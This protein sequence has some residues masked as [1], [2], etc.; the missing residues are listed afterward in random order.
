MQTLN[1]GQCY[2]TSAA[3]GDTYIRLVSSSGV[4]VASN[5]DS[6]NLFSQLIYTRTLQ[7]CDTYSLREG[8]YQAQ[9]C[10]GLMQYGIGND[11][12]VSTAAPGSV[13]TAAP[14]S[15]PTAAPGSVPTAAPSSVPT[16]A[17]TFSIGSTIVEFDA[18]IVLNNVNAGSFM[19]DANAQLS[20]RNATAQAMAGVTIADVTVLSADDDSSGRRLAAAPSAGA[21]GARGLQI[22]TQRTRVTSHVSASTAQL[23]STC[24]NCQSGDNAFAYMTSS[25]DNSISTG[26]YTN[27]LQQASAASGATATLAATVT[28]T[29][30]ITNFQTYTVTAVPAARPLDNAG[31][32]AGSVS[33]IIV[34][35]IMCAVGYHLHQCTQ[36][37]VKFCDFGPFAVRRSDGRNATCISKQIATSGVVV[38]SGAVKDGMDDL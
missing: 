13:P 2:D 1:I 7:G 4:V 20:F 33:S 27:T 5:D 29:A 31:A 16:A 15:V 8:C 26:G 38:E 23:A 34:L 10:S 12:S 28:E 3:T 11:G 30:N 24:S 17:P 9:S 35:L 22:T 18:G 36:G 19:A 25:L 32:I 6:C 21:A 37:K 14:G